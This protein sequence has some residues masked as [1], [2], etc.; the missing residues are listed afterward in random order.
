[1]RRASGF[2]LLEV[3]AGLVVLG[4]IIVLLTHSVDFA[5]GSWQRQA[6]ELTTHDE[7]EPID[8]ALR[9]LIEQTD[10]G[11]PGWPPVFEGRAHTMLL[12]TEMPDVPAG[13]AVAALG[14][15]EAHQLVLTWRSRLVR[16]AVQHST[17]LLEG[18]ERLDIGYWQPEANVWLDSWSLHN[19]PA[20]VRF[21]VVFQ[22]GD[23]RRMPD[24]IAAPMRARPYG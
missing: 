7:L 10:P 17:V 2:T 20:L 1:M 12:A 5:L 8:R 4:L 15:N 22:H 23:P 19:L 21:R 13:E 14:T 6:F 11:D 9:R 24:L 3:L 16:P 18:V